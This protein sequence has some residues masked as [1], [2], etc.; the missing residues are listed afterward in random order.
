MQMLSYFKGKF[1]VKGKGRSFH[2]NFKNCAESDQLLVYKLFFLL[3]L[4]QK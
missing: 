2:A 1:K 3:L 4:A